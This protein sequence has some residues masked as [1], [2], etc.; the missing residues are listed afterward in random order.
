MDVVDPNTWD[1]A[2][3]MMMMMMVIIVNKIMSLGPFIS[4]SFIP[5]VDIKGQA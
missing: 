3:L 2:L 4:V 1:K 5:C